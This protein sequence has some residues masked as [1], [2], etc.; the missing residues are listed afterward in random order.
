MGSQ[1]SSQLLVLRWN[2]IQPFSHSILSLFPKVAAKIGKFQ[3]LS[4]FVFGILELDT[5]RDEDL[6]KSQLLKGRHK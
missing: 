1:G 4:T 3:P 6:H 2:R 5:T